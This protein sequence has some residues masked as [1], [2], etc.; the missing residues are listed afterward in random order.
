ML[1]LLFS[2]ITFLQDLVKKKLLK[3]LLG[4]EPVLCR[5][6]NT[7]ITCKPSHP[8]GSYEENYSGQCHKFILCCRSTFARSVNPTHPVGSY[9]H[10]E[11]VTTFALVAELL[12]SNPTQVIFCI[13]NICLVFHCFSSLNKGFMT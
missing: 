13:D 10:G 4:I 3:E 9:A 5:T 6:D 12:S 1:I 7:A 11:V 8:V 2:S